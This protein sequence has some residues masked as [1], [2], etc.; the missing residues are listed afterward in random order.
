MVQKNAYDLDTEYIANMKCV[1][2]IDVK[3]AIIV[4]MFV[5]KSDALTIDGWEI[6][7][8][9]TLILNGYKNSLF[10]A[11]SGLRRKRRD[12]VTIPARNRQKV[13]QSHFCA[14]YDS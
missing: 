13:R 2:R 1:K 6:Y 8:L 12:P 11:L 5:I 3:R 14:V 7:G 4:P 9:T 10:A